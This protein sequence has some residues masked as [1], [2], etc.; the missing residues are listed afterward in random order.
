MYIIHQLGAALSAACTACQQ[1]VKHVSTEYSMSAL[2]AGDAFL[3]DEYVQN[4]KQCSTFSHPK[5]IPV[6]N[7]SR[8][9][10]K[11]SKTPGNQ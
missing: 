10:S 2:S 1:R 5:Q 8:F 11:E 4:W 9:I 7:M 6:D 3:R